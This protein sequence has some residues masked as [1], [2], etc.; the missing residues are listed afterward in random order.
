MKIKL[1]VVRAK[2]AV[3]RCSAPP[4]HVSFFLFFFIQQI[5]ICISYKYN[6]SLYKKLCT[7]LVVYRKSYVQ[8]SLLGKKSMRISYFS[9]NYAYKLYA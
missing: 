9:N 5:F 4:P 8:D 6:S 7:Q 3:R 1:A 2:R